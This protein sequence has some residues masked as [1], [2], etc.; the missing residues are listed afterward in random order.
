MGLFDFLKRKEKPVAP[1]E[2]L[3]ELRR[4]GEGCRLNNHTSRYEHL[5]EYCELA[6]ELIPDYNILGEEKIY[7]LRLKALTQLE[8]ELKALAEKNQR[9][10]N[11]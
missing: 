8:K 3:E 7:P 1:A 4:L 10:T 6:R 9:Q 5:K 2:K 11:Q